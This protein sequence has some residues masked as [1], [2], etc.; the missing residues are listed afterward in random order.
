VLEGWDRDA[1][2]TSRCVAPEQSA[3]AEEPGPV[4]AIFWTV[5]L[6]ESNQ[7][8]RIPPEE[9]KNPWPFSAVIIGS[10]WLPVLAIDLCDRWP[11]NGRQGR[12]DDGRSRASGLITLEGVPAE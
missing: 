1:V 8:V 4:G 3:P 11:P 10:P 5:T 12:N 9:P 2:G 7:R 6:L